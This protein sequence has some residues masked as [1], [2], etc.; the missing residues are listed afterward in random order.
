MSYLL[1]ALSFLFAA[2]P[3]PPAN[4]N[5][6]SISATSTIQL[7]ADQIQ[8]NIN[9]NAEAESPQ[10]AYELHQK[11][12]A[13]L[14]KMLDKYNISE[15]DIRFQP[16]SIN[17]NSYNRRENEEPT[18]ETRQSVQVTLED[19][20]A[21]EDIQIGLIENN[22]DDFSGRFASTKSEKGQDKALRK[23]VQKAKAKARII[24]DET[25]I[26]LGP[27]INISYN[28]NQPRPYAQESA[29]LKAQSDSGSLL[30]YNQT[31]SISATVSME[32]DILIGN[33]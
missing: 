2:Q 22:F 23:A 6:L 15:K 29:Q 20:D 19:F 3:S 9:I 27:V 1:I 10:K 16:I 24:A 31:V 11:R 18:V 14:V 13:A 4:S 8:F 21:Y 32:F 5:G 26:K 12:E 28:V 7:P 33:S 25:G 17:K 30:K